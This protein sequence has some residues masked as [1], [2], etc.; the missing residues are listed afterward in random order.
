MICVSKNGANYRAAGKD[1]IPS[2]SHNER[3]W[4]ALPEHKS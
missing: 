1:E 4:L 2:L 3:A